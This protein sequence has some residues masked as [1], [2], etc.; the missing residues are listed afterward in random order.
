MTQAGAE[1]RIAMYHCKKSG[2]PQ[3]GNRVDDLYEVCGQ[4]VKSS[5]WLQPERL[6]RQLLH[7][8]TLPS[9]RG[10][11]RGDEA[12]V[13]RFSRPRLA[14][15]RAVQIYVQPGISRDGRAQRISQLLAATNF[16]LSQGGV[17][18]FRAHH[19]LA[20]TVGTSCTGCRPYGLAQ[21]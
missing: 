17:D 20:P 2:A 9:V 19:Q 10:F 18:S 7:R 14:A 5:M 1:L 4:A 3:P 8:A 11:L 15:R 16:Y 6:L 21:G 13:E 12:E